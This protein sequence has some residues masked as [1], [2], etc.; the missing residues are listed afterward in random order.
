MP[1]TDMSY[2]RLGKTGLA[3]STVGLGC[4][5]FGR[6]IDLDETRKVVDA[7]IDEGVNFF[8]TA[9]RYQPSE[10]FLGEIL[11]ARRDD[12]VI[13]TKF[14]MDVQGGNGEDWGARG[15]RRYVRRAVERSLR[16]L[17]TDWIDLYQIHR[18]D[19]ETPIDETLS[20][21]TDL[22]HE[23]KVRYIGSSG[24]TA[25]RIVDAEW[26]ARTHGSERFTS[27]QNEY[28]LLSR[29]LEADVVPACEE[30]GIGVVPYSPLA[31]G[32]LTGKYRRGEPAP[33][34]SRIETWRMDSALTDEH[35][36]VIERLSD[37]AAERS[38]TLLDVAIGGLAAQPMVA[39]VIAGATNADQVHAN[40]AAGRWVPT[41]ED[42]AILDEIA[43]TARPQ[44]EVIRLPTF[45]RPGTLQ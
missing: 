30:Y 43:P 18:P 28:S 13:A 29:G 36:D 22:V 44:E 6:K 25:W 12:I 4:N 23:G 37:F 11:G 41:N 1:A 34:G 17:Q 33:A 10:E 16:L 24:M 7:A 38:I 39:S 42:L 21:L 35:F 40:V 31:N 26:V 19:P 3:V 2:R 14:G 32:L 8:D 5:N 45:N 9:D 20:V 15:S 27:V